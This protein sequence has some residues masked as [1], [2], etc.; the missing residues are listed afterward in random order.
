MTA[1]RG[2]L[3]WTPDR[4][5]TVAGT[6]ITGSVLDGPDVEADTRHW[7]HQEALRWRELDD[8]H[9]IWLL[10]RFQIAL[11]QCEQM[12]ALADAEDEHSES[13]TDDE[14]QARGRAVSADRP[15]GTPTS[16]PQYVRLDQ[17][18]SIAKRS[19]KTLERAM[20]RPGS[21]APEPDIRGGGG[22]F[23]EW[24]W[25]RIRPWLEAEF[26]RQFPERFPTL[27]GL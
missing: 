6:T 10:T 3:D 14:H 19:K 12:A 27:D 2:L 22:K 21:K 25:D 15:V 17:L 26:H 5:R 8:C 13:D 1:V 20:N 7:N 23:H 4:V 16:N 11:E 24:R 18:A 9:L